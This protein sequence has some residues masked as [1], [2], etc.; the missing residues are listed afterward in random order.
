MLIVIEGLDYVGKSTQVELLSKYLTAEG[1]T[2]IETVRSPGGNANTPLAEYLRNEQFFLRDKTP[3]HR[4]IVGSLTRSIVS[5][6]IKTKR[7]DHVVIADR[8]IRSGYAYQV[9]GEQTDPDLFKSLYRDVLIPDL[10]IILTLTPEAYEQRKQYISS[11]APETIISDVM[12]EA[13]ENKQFK[14]RVVQAFNQFSYF[15]PYTFTKT[16]DISGLSI[17]EV[18]QA[19]IKEIDSRI[20]LSASPSS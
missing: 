4:T 5:D 16:I 12:E 3:L 10:E 13:L 8:W 19:I 7:N 1:H 9:G 6:Y 15:G 11:N 20:V 2:G 17:I 14:E 18:H